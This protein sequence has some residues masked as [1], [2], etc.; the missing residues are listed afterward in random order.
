MLKKADKKDFIDKLFDI[1]MFE[2]MYKLIHKDVLVLEKESLA[3]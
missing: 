3:C 1:S 2:S